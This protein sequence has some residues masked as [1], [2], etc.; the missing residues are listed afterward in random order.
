MKEKL[1]IKIAR[2]KKAIK[3]LER[4]AEFKAFK[5]IEV[6]A[7]VGFIITSVLLCVLCIYATDLYVLN[8]FR[9][10]IYNYCI[11]ILV[12]VGVFGGCYLF[13]IINLLLIKILKQFCVKRAIENIEILENEE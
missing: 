7:I 1:L 8:E 5:I 12:E 9:R 2:T 13:Q 6:L 4:V 11:A 3:R 10:T